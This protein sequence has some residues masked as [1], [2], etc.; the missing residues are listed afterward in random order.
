VLALLT[1]VLAA[2]ESVG[3]ELTENVSP[4]V[5]NPILPTL[6]EMFWAAVL[7]CALWA[8]M[9]FVLLPP[10]MRTFE[11]RE[12]KI[13]EDK[14]AAEAA[15]ADRIAK[16]QEYESGLI[17][18]RA[19]AVRVIE[20]ARAQ[21][22]AQRREAVGVAEAEVAVKRAEAAEEISAAKAQARTELAGSIAALAVGA[23]E[24]VVERPIDRDAAGPVVEEYVNRAGVAN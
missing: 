8:L 7:F 22:E 15:E 18:A 5:S 9:K 14:L 21:G 12:T 6:N 24:A 23:A 20:D 17:G 19:E 13:R 16:L 10:L 3:T 2:A 1:P 11:A 4:E